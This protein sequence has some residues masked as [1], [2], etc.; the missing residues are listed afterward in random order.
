MQMKTEVRTSTKDRRGSL[1]P[2]PIFIIAEMASSHQ[3]NPVLAREIIDGAGRSAANAIQ[4]QIW[5]VKDMVVPDHSEYDKLKKIELARSDWVELARYSRERYPEMQIIACVYETSSVDFAAHLHVDAYK[6]HAS[7]LSNPSLVKRVAATGKRIHLSVGAATISEIQSAIQWIREV[8]RSL[9]WLM[10]GFQNFPTRTKDVRLNEMLNL[11]RRFQLPIGYQDHSD[12]ESGSAFWIPAAVIGMGVNIIEKHITYDRSLKGIDHEAALNPDEFARFVEMVREIEAAK[13]QQ[14]KHDVLTPEE[15][16]YRQYAKKSIVASHRLPK[17]RQLAQE[18]LLFMRANDLG[19]P[20]DQAPRLIGRFTKRDIEAYELIREQDVQK[21]VA[22]LITGRLKSTRLPVKA[23][24]PILGRPMIVHQLERLK[25]AKY[26][27]KIILCTST[28]PQD[29]PLEEIA[30]QSSV[31][32]FRGHPEDV[33][34][35]LTDA[36]SHYG[37]DVVVSCTAD[38]PFVDPVYLDRLVEFS[39]EHGCDYAD[40]EGLPFGTFSYV[41]S[42][43]AMVRACQ[44]KAEM[45][46]ET[47]GAYF[48]ETGL[49]KVATLH[50]TDPAVRRPGLRLTVDTPEDFDLVSK[51]FDAL[52]GKGHVFSLREIVA[53][54]DLHPELVKVNAHVKQAPVKPIRLKPRGSRYVPKV[55]FELGVNHLGDVNKAHRMVDLLVAGGA[56][57]V[58]LQAIF[59]QTRFQANSVLARQLEKYCLNYEDTISVIRHAVNVGLEVGVVAVDPGD[60]SR[61]SQA[62]GIGFFK[63][64]S[65]DITFG[66]LLRE[67]ALTSLPIYLSTAASTLDDIQRAIH[68]IRLLSPHA[69][70]RLIHTVLHQPT[71]PHML[72]LL[73]IPALAELL[74][75]PVAYGQHSD[76]PQAVYSAIALGAEAVFLYVAETR[77]PELPDGPHAV[78]CSQVPDLLDQVGRVHAML[79]SRDRVVTREEIEAQQ[80]LRSPVSETGPIQFEGVHIA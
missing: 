7:D 5:S 16:K 67:I 25:L 74:E 72:N 56:Q 28:L 19:L 77:E 39:L 51:I 34:Q 76:D 48:T 59:N 62:A 55:I 37:I 79:G 17:G 33:L 12:A 69:D 75:V 78:L 22:I 1:S 24:K 64:L 53:H 6:V 32:C 15:S 60:V 35:R 20:P 3:G 43:P 41:L 58:S 57:Y 66:P 70:V 50:V 14:S 36:A 65:A 54:C 52:H 18:D 73:N 2:H 26:P 11:R 23:L 38:N 46:T 8:S 30:L 29:D 49:F 42:Y 44:V 13:R 63:V 4:F 80:E 9:I 71:P 21:N 47:W 45:D 10:Y 68:C 40:I 27:Q 31:E 61:L